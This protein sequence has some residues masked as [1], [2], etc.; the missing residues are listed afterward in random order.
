MDHHDVMQE[1]I[2]RFQLHLNDP[3]HIPTIPRCIVA[4]VLLLLLTSRNHVERAV[5][6][7]G[8]IEVEIKIEDAV[9]T[10]M[11]SILMPG[12][13]CTVPFLLEHHRFVRRD[14]VASA[15][16]LCNSLHVRT[17]QKLE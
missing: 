8:A 3:W 5:S 14:E 17:A 13:L 16:T 7:I 2:T 11:Y 10:G 6:S 12:N 15:Q 1:H 9:S 4:D